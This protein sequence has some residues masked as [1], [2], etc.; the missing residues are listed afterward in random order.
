MADPFANGIERGIRGLAGVFQGGERASRE[1]LPQTAIAADA[2]AVSADTRSLLQNGQQA[3]Q[4]LRYAPQEAAT[5]MPTFVQRLE[6]GQARVNDPALEGGLLSSAHQDLVRQTS[7]MATAYRTW[8]GQ[9]ESTTNKVLF[10]PEQYDPQTV[11]TAST[12]RESLNQLNELDRR[13]TAQLDQLD[14]QPLLNP[15]TKRAAYTEHAATAVDLAKQVQTIMQQLH[16]R[17]G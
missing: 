7:E 5:R 6:Q 12:V 14:A 11:R 16:D 9:M 15:S 4:S 3:I 2:H 17:L 13:T 1:A 8:R 10:K